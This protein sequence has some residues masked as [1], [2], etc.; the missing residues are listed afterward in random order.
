MSGEALGPEGWSIA[1]HPLAAVGYALPAAA[2]KNATVHLP[3]KYLRLT[4]TIYE[5]SSR[6][7]KIRAG[8][9]GAKNQHSR[10]GSDRRAYG[11]M[12]SSRVPSGSAA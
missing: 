10:A 12:L 7:I 8:L 6:R 1:S 9:P 3:V 4:N 2:V 5:V 11:E